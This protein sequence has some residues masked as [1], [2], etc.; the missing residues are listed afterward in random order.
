MILSIYYRF[1]HKIPKPVGPDGVVGACAASRVTE[2][3]P[4]RNADVSAT[5]IVLD[6]K[7]DIAIAILG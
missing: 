2:D 3:C 7:S 6:Q 4:I 1:T 5:A